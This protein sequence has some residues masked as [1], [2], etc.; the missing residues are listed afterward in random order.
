MRKYIYT[1]AET[2]DN[3]DPQAFEDFLLF[4]KALRL[5]ILLNGKE[6]LVPHTTLCNIRL[7]SSV[8]VYTQI[9]TVL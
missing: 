1:S 4:L 7:Y 9:Y 2:V 6:L 5:S 8:Y 3:I